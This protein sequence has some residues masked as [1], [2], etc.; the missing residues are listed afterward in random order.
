MGRF[1]PNGKAGY[2]LKPRILTDNS[3]TFDPFEML[4]L[5]GVVPL[6]CTITVRLTACM[7]HSAWVISCCCAGHLHARRPLSQLPARCGHIH[8]WIAG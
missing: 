4:A 3:K 7:H 5:Q 6:T 2:A 8:G 1:V